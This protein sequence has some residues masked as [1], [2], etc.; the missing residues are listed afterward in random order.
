MV[1]AFLGVSA[2]HQAIAMTFARNQFLSP[3]GVVR[4][5]KFL[6]AL[7]LPPTVAAIC[8]PALGVVL[9]DE[10]TSTGQQA[11]AESRE[12]EQDQ[13]QEPSASPAAPDSL[14]EALAKA[15][16]GHEAYIGSRFAR[17]RSAAGH[18]LP[19]DFFARLIWQEGRF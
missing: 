16:T 19:A 12:A 1:V 3:G 18:D 14:C 8:P 10:P 11:P 17:K 6:L 13:Q 9:A 15:A 7:L 4:A 2:H 5:S